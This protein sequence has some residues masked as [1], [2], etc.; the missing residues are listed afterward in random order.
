MSHT[1]GDGAQPVP[2]N[3]GLVGRL[4]RSAGVDVAGSLYAVSDRDRAVVAR[5][6]AR[7]RLWIHADVFAD[8]RQGVC[9]DLIISLAEAGTGRVDVHLLTEGALAA[10]DVV[11]RPGIAR[12]TF[13]YEGTDNVEAVAA[14]AR[15]TGARPW[16]AISPRTQVDDCR[17]A[18]AH[19]DGLLVMLI[20]PGTRE[21]ADLAQLVK[22]KAAS[23]QRPVG[24][25]GGVGEWNVER[26]LAAGATYVVVGRRLFAVSESHAAGEER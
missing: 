10:L 24:V 20:E 6:L 26:I 8:V 16:L 5:L 3:T 12:L 15:A 7:H 11:C 4:R 17:D 23:A 9:L 18:L 1:A 21:R 19:V 22:V 2:F 13:P 14:R 25:D